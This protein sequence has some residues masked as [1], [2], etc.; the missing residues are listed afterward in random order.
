MNKKQKQITTIPAGYR[1]SVTSWENDA[2]NY[3][4]KVMAGLSIDDVNFYVDLCKS[5]VSQHKNRNAF[6]NMFDPRNDERDK[7][8]KHVKTIIKNNNRIDYNSEHWEDHIMGLL[9]DLGLSCG[10]F[11]TR[12]CDKFKV[13]YIAEPI[14]IDDV[15]S[16]FTNIIESTEFNIS[17]PLPPPLVSKFI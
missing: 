14:V 13:E 16:D 6:G 12:V 7:F 3:N 2:D 5:L 11:F 17:S 1:L 10:D 9:Y 4:T 15:T 8:F